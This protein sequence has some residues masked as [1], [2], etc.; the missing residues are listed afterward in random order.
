MIRKTSREDLLAEVM[1]AGSGHGTESAMESSQ[2]RKASRPPPV[3]RAVGRPAKEPTVQFT[4]KLRPASARLLQEL[5][6]NLQGRAI[7]GEITRSEATIA[8]IVEQALELYAKKHQHP[9]QA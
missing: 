7:R 5:Q 4:L 2:G 8:I 1:G 6:S 3:S 9:K